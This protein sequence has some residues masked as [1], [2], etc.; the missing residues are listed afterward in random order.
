MARVVTFTGEE[1]P[2]TGFSQGPA[3][4][5]CELRPSPP[6]HGEGISTECELLGKSRSMAFFDKSGSQMS[7][8]SCGVTLKVCSL[9]SFQDLALHTC[10]CP[11][12]SPS[13]SSF[14]RLKL[15][16]ELCFVP[17]SCLPA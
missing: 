12:L 1:K 9:P 16:A 15:L 11:G 5:L 10:P 17:S 14:T 2:E 3:V 8:P 6:A 7:V 13:C 4:V